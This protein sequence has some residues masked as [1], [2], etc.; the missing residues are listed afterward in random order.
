MQ[1]SFQVAH[2]KEISEEIGILLSD[3]PQAE[4]RL[5]WPIHDLDRKPQGLVVS[6][7]ISCPTLTLL[8][9]YTN[10]QTNLF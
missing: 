4:H 6:T 2:K 3:H 10:V 9:V 8:S 7:S 1:Y 5:Q